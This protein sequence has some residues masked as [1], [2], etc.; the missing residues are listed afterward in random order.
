MSQCSL[1]TA[2]RPE[3]AAGAPPFLLFC[4]LCLQSLWSVSTSFTLLGFSRCSHS[5]LSLLKAA[6]LE[7]LPDMVPVYPGLSPSYFLS[8]RWGKL[9]RVAGVLTFPAPTLCAVFFSFSEEAEPSTISWCS[10]SVSWR[11]IRLFASRSQVRE[12]SYR[13]RRKS[14]CFQHVAAPWSLGSLCHG[15]LLV[16]PDASSQTSVP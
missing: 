15:C 10:F 8:A 12:P 13:S 2:I 6:C 4:G 7:Q 11:M 5:N 14:S 16:S 1:L 9:P 3:W